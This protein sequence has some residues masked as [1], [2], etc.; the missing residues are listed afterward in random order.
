M[1][2]S[3]VGRVEIVCTKCNEI[4]HYFNK[5]PNITGRTATE[6]G[7]SGNPHDGRRPPGARR[8]RPRAHGTAR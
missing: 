3:E 2:E 5:C 4:G 7:P 1:D 6:A 8:A